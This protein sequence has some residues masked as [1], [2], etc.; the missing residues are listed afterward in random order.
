V[1]EDDPVCPLEDA[2]EIAA[3]L[4]P[5]WMHLARFPGVGHR[6]WRDDPDAAY[7]VLRRFIQG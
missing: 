1:G 6:A 2:L 7:P 3:A 4:P 5:Q